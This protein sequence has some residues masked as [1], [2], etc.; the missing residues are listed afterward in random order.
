VHDIPPTGEDGEAS[1]FIDSDLNIVAAA[2]GGGGGPFGDPFC[3]NPPIAPGG[4]GT[5][6]PNSISRVGGSGQTCPTGGATIPAA[7][8]SAPTGSIT[9]SPSAAGQGGNGASS[10]SPGQPGSP[11]YVLI[12]W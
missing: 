8:G 1:Q 6:G 10:L 9:P 5:L 3:S 7:G 12:T 2:N 4:G 11:G